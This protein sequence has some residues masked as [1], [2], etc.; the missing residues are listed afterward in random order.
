MNL[1]V[2]ELDIPD[3]KLVMPKRL[4]DS[5]GFFSETYTKQRFADAG[6]D[7]SFVQ[8]NHSLS[9]KRGT[10][11]GL[12]YQSPPFDQAKLVR[13]IRGSIIDV[14]VDVRK[15]SP[16]YGKWVRVELNADSPAQ[17]FIPSGFLHGFA[18]LE[19]NTE[20]AYKVDAYYSAE[21]DGSVIWND[22][23]L[24]IDWSIPAGT[25][26]VSEKDQNAPKFL[27]FDSPFVYEP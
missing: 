7:I 9:Y 11:R 27:N 24:C 15:G 16:Y 4:S 21:C 13:V 19:D 17:I 22:Q 2:S 20:I 3:V 8:D 5:R 10:I 25:E 14:A 1:K 12:H 18:T 23:T 26:T 6:I